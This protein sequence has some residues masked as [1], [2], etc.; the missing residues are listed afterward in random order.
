MITLFL[1]LFSAAIGG[2]APVD[3][4]NP[5]GKWSTDRG[6]TIEVKRDGRFVF[7]DSGFCEIGTYKT[8]GA[9]EVLLL[10]FAKMK[11]TQRLIHLSGEDEALAMNASMPLTEE[12]RFGFDIGD[13]GMSPELQ[14]ELCRG[15]PCKIIGRVKG[16]V[17][18]FRKIS[19][20]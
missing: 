12:R 14:Y 5:Y 2:Q 15:R 17:Y 16:D 11:S 19:D 6:Q 20:Y 10:N 8:D 13:G 4:G 18:R 3:L 7:C 9:H 1:A